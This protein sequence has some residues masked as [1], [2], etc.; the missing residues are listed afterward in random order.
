MDV[1]EEDVKRRS[2]ALMRRDDFYRR[3]KAHELINQLQPPDMI[4]KVQS[5]LGVDGKI[6]CICW[7]YYLLSMK[8]LLILISKWVQPLLDPLFKLGPDHEN[9]RRFIDRN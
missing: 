8:V 3:V 1:T 9:W 5:L 6:F 4:K 2:N 7:R